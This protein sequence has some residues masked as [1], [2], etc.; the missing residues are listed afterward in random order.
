MRGT[1]RWKTHRVGHIT[2]RYPDAPLSP[3]RGRRILEEGRA[4]MAPPPMPLT[5]QA[6]ASSHSQLILQH[7][8][9]EKMG[10]GQNI[11]MGE[12]RIGSPVKTVSY[13][14]CSKLISGQTNIRL[15]P[16]PT[17]PP[18][19]HIFEK[20]GRWQNVWM[21]GSRIGSQVKTVSCTRSSR[22]TSGQTNS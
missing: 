12:S 13:T 19:S 7:L 20:M 11:W 1:R 17:H 22:V 5:L 18:A 21:G 2:S 15:Q 14:R 6:S 9:L 10:W 4:G 8:T 3:P 16:L